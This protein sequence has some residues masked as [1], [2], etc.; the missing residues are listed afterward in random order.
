MADYKSDSEEEEDK[1]NDG[2]QCARH[3]FTP[4]DHV[5]MLLKSMYSFDLS[6]HSRVA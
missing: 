1:S 2:V 3:K 5:K 6:L 4:P